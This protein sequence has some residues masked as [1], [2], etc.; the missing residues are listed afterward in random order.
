MCASSLLGS[1]QE[2]WSFP[3]AKYCRKMSKSHRKC[4]LPTGK[5]RRSPSEMI[6]WEINLFWPALENKIISK[7]KK[8]SEMKERYGQKCYPFNT[9][10]LFF[11]AFTIIN[12]ELTREVVIGNKVLMRE[13]GVKN[14]LRCNW[15]KKIITRNPIDYLLFVLFNLVF[16]EI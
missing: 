12:N 3:S 8:W 10:G 4:I 13:V 2:I 5:G 6:S 14:N 16:V 15:K 9:K 1:L 11:T 7:G